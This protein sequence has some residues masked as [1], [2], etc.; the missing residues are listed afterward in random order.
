[1][2]DF[3]TSPI[4]TDE[5]ADQAKAQSKI[6]QIGSTTRAGAGF[7]EAFARFRPSMLGD[8]MKPDMEWLLAFDFKAAIKRR[9]ERGCPDM[10]VLDN[11]VQG[12]ERMTPALRE[13]V[14]ECEDC[15]AVLDSLFETAALDEIEP[16]NVL[17]RECL[18]GFQWLRAEALGQLH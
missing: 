15:Q 5:S 3:G 4:Y 10:E 11:V 18:A 9:L 12:F 17:A 13:H 14:R 7:H 1:M 6:R 16:M 2:H 8:T